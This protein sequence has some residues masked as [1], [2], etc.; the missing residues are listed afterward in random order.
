MFVQRVNRSLKIIQKNKIWNHRYAYAT[1]SYPVDYNFIQRSRIPTMHFQG[2]LPRLPIPHLDLTC[3]RYLAAQKP[4]LIDEAYNKTESNV[5]QFKNSLGKRLQQLL[6]DYDKQNTNTSYISEFW[7]DNYLKERKPLPINCNP[8]LIMYNDCRQEYCNQLIRACNLI[9]SSIRFYKSL[10]AD[11]LEPEVYHLNP[12]RSD[13]EL[14]RAIC[15]YLP[16]SLSWYGA[17]MFKAYPLDM[18]Q[19]KSLF[20][21]TRIPETDKDRLIKNLGGNHI[22][23]QYRGHFYAFAI[24]DHNEDI[25]PAE[26]ILARLKFI[27]EDDI[28]KNPFPIGVLTTMERDR[29]ATLRHELIENGNQ[30]SLK[31]IDS[32]IFNVC[33]DDISVN[34]DPYATIRNALHAD[35]ENRW[36]DKSLSLQVSRDG[37][38]AINFEN[39]WGDGVAVLRYI[40][41]VYKDSV[42]NPQV[43]PDTQPYDENIENVIRLDIHLNDKLKNSIQ[44]AKKLYKAFCNSLDI[45]YLIYDK[46]GR[47]ICKK[48]AV[49]PDS[50]M[51]LGFQIAYHKIT[52]KFVPTYESCSTAAFKHGRT[53][54][55]RSCT[56]ATQAFTL[57][58][59]GKDK[60]SINQLKLMINDCSRVHNQLTREAAMG[61]GFD[62]HLYA[63]KRIAEKTN[64]F[65]NIFDD[66]DFAYL[67]HIILSTSTLSSP[68]IYAGGF[69]PM[70]KDGIGIGYMIK[71]DSLRVLVSSY[72]PYQNGSDFVS[73]LRDTFAELVII[74]DK[75]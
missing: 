57:A 62:R 15:S 46:I 49:S 28:E 48:Q 14:F 9:I 20:N 24:L 26:K 11:L 40:Q 5:T 13:T 4:L 29:W 27:M 58:I 3:E 56:T 6:K 36:F 71:D 68:M 25:L 10:Q 69:G 22:T 16:T 2:S 66:P 60:P 67:N 39:S 52:G 51:Q 34:G 64:T 70:E 45:D 47:N 43:H 35:G 33:L 7:F 17:Y 38:A 55:V 74:L 65:C 61:Q 37:V 30:H 73:A 12:Y 44:E 63:L 19:Y 21:T 1:I 32:A 23:V 72:P 41:D 42:D 8:A 59:N 18:S 31:L 50:I 54:I 75:D 53:E